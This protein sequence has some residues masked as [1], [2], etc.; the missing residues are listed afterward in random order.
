[1]RTVNVSRS[2]LESTSESI[3]VEITS[4]RYRRSPIGKYKELVGTVHS[5]PEDATTV[6]CC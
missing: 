5:E 2:P 4:S 3:H 6:G 1:M